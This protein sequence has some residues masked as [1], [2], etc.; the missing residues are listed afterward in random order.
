M[1]DDNARQ[2]DELKAL[3]VKALEIEPSNT[4]ALDFISAAPA[5][6]MLF[7]AEG[8]C[9]W[10][11]ANEGRFGIKNAGRFRA[12]YREYRSGKQP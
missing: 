10:I 11:E 2:A 3:L 12:S 7:G 4:R 5:I 1:S 8:V 9:G 6:A